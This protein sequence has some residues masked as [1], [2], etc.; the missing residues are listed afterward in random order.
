[1][2]KLSIDNFLKVYT[3]PFIIYFKKLSINGFINNIIIYKPK[4]KNCL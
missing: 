2:Q 3:Y 4:S 1:M